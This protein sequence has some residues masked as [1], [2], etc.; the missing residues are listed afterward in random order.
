MG[1]VT[2]ILVRPYLY[3]CEELCP[4]ESLKNVKLTINT[5]KTENNQEIPSVSV[6]II[7]N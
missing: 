6:I 1:N 4:L 5:I 3:V 7:L 2:K